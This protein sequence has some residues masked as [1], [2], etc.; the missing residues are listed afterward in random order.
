MPSIYRT[1]DDH[2]YKTEPNTP[3]HQ[4]T[5]TLATSRSDPTPLNSAFTSTRTIFD[6]TGGSPKK[7]VQKVS[8]DCP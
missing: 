1:K 2:S 3:T 4:P 5:Q 6:D 7:P 8:C